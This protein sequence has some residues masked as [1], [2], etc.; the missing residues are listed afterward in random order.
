MFSILTTLMVTSNIAQAKEIPV[1]S[2]SASSYR[3]PDSGGKYDANLL[4][5]NKST[6][7]W[8][9][10]DEGSGMGSW[11]EVSL[12]EAATISSMK[13]W[14]GNWYSFNEWDFY[15]RGSRVDIF[16]EDGAK[17]SFDLSD[18]KKVEDIKFAK[19]HTGKT[20]KIKF[21]KVHAGSTYA[22]RLAVSEVKFYDSTAENFAVANISAS[23]TL[24][25]D[26][27]GSYEAANLQDGL[28][29]TIW[30]EGSKGDGAGESLVYDFGGAKKLSSIALV[31]GNATDFKMFM[32]YGS[33]KTV[34][35]A[36]D[37]GSSQTLTF[38]PSLM[39]QTLTLD[40]VKASK[41]TI[42]LKDVK[43]GSKVQ[44]TCLSE[45]RFN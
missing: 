26:N 3:A 24:P 27:D 32:G 37:N 29:D 4:F 35:V 44:D 14:N 1:A 30:C 25:E 15:N 42:T 36:F 16:F 2:A 39:P 41:A 18:N 28:K 33:V 43:A 7:A 34:E 9:E 13:L 10:D 45:L 11:F 38:K 20:V 5:D 17:E 31:N 19:P 8:V 21:V 40:P 6:T 22:D 23:S 12:K